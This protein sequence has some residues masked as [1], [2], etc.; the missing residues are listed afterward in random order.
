LQRH[1]Q[2]KVQRYYRSMFHSI[3]TGK[4]SMKRALWLTGLYRFELRR[5]LARF[6][7]PGMSWSNWGAWE[8]HHKAACCAFD[9]TDPL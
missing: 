6:F 4:A 7:Q 5:H 2:R 9:L 3:V 1:E 8:I